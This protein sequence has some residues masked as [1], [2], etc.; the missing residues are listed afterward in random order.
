[1]K[2]ITPNI[3]VDDINTTIEYYKKIGFKLT[4]TV[5]NEGD[6]VWAMMNCGNVMFM[7]QTFES[8]GNNCQKFQEKW[9]LSFALYRS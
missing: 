4:T 8:L 1:M 9:R 5:P 6:I 7:L 2:A 3:F